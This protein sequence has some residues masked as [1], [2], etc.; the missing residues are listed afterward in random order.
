MQILTKS[1][2]KHYARFVSLLS[3]GLCRLHQYLCLQTTENL[4]QNQQDGINAIVEYYDTE[5]WLILDQKHS[6]QVTDHRF[7]RRKAQKSERR[8]AQM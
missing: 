3:A 6:G 8:S 2:H 4:G 5:T 1:M 7:Q